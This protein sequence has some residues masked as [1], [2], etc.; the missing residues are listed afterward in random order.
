MVQDNS[1]KDKAGFADSLVTRLSFAIALAFIVAG[2]ILSVIAVKNA[3]AMV[4]GLSSDAALI[5]E[6]IAAL[7][8][9]MIV[10]TVI[11]L[12]VFSILFYVIITLVL[13]PIFDLIGI[14]YQTSDFD[15]RHNPR[16][17]ALCARKDEFGLISNAIR[18]M[19]SKLR[20]IVS[21]I[22]DAADKI[23]TDVD[24]L[25][26]TAD[27]VN[28]MCTD[29]YATTEELAASMQMC[30]T[31]VNDIKD[32]IKAIQVSNHQIEMMSNDGTTLS[33]E[34]MQRA[35]DLKET[36]DKATRTTRDMYN[37]V[38]IK[39]DRAMESSKAVG[40]INELTSTIMSISSQT[41]LLALNASIEA[42][43]AGE[44]GRGFAVVATEI[45]NLADDT[46]KAVSNINEIVDEVNSAVSQ[47]Q[48]CLE[49]MI[50]FLET[51]V[52]KDYEEFGQVSIRYQDDADIFKDSMSSIKNGVDDLTE[53]IGR[54]VETIG[55]INST[56]SESAEGVTDIADRTTDIVQGM[57]DTH[58]KVGECHEYVKVLEATI[59]KFN[60]G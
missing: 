41:S 49:E 47:M 58:T 59:G 18:V 25:S 3:E 2:V 14:I 42:A 30:A 46:S 17:G 48:G 19:R 57:G 37:D 6:T 1:R 40:K 16:S 39:S 4:S 15:L 26:S 27:V 12:I 45:G 22:D 43:R 55:A 21:D 29:N 33:H 7:R 60:R 34:I 9:K 54:I 23:G 8:I 36:T 53:A 28:S 5:K 24:E 35:T 56:V 31:N 50:T 13:R 11:L 38:K 44:A 32:D 51:T 20:E 10:A 52:L